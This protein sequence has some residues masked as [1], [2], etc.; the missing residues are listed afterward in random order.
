MWGIALLLG[1]AASP[2]AM[3]L[4]AALLFVSRRRPVANLLAF[5]LGGVATGLASAI[6]VVTLLRDFSPVVI[7]NV[8]ARC[9]GGPVMIALGV[10][11]LLIAALNAVGLAR[12]R[13]PVP[14]GGGD[15]AAA[16][17]QQRK[18]GTVSR[19]AARAQQL[20][21]GGRPWVAFAAGLGQLPVPVEYVALLSVSAASGAAIGTQFCAAIAYTIGMFAI[22]EI[23]LVAYLVKPEQTQAIMLSVSHWLRVHYRRVLVVIGA[24]VGMVL[25][26]GGMSS[27]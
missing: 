8:T 13:A 25:V 4:G 19:L 23:P 10:L 14:T 9:T 24:T 1:I 15:P 18:P 21:A 12:R 6:L 5:L 22:I 27:I 11:A 3:R 16:A 20:L 26:A 17:P 2:D 7:R